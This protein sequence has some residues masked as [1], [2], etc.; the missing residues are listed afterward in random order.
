MTKKQHRRPVHPS[1]RRVTAAACLLAAP[2]LVHLASGSRATAA[3]EPGGTLASDGSGF[4]AD[5]V[6]AVRTT[7]SNLDFSPDRISL[8]QGT[9]VTIRYINDSTLPHNIVIVRNEDD[10][11]ALGMAA[12]SASQTGYVP[13][14]HAGKMLAYSPLAVPGNSVE[15]NFVMPPPGEYFFVCLYPGHYNMMVG[16]LRSLN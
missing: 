11:D 14:E 10:I 16:T 8:R 15:I 12:F 2:V 7:G 9:R 6:I 1:L 4:V 5:T 3:G 13:V